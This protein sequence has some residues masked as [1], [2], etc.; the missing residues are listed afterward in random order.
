LILGRYGGI[1]ESLQENTRHIE[2]ICPSNRISLSVISVRTNQHLISIQGNR[3][4]EEVILRRRRVVKRLQQRGRRCAKEVCLSYV[5]T[6]SIVI[7]SADQDVFSA[8]RHRHA[9]MVFGGNRWIIEGLQKGTRCHVEEV[10]L[11]NV[12]AATVVLARTD[13]DATSFQSD[14]RP[15]SIVSCRI[16]VVE[17][18]V[19]N[20]AFGNQ[21]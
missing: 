18:S 14:T 9:K 2:K 13:Q 7:P 11:A 6:M 21:W 20:K 3:P 19:K 16:R 8:Q 4:A 15:E 10:C 12:C 1:V 5:F 17:G